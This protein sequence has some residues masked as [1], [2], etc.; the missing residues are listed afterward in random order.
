MDSGAARLKRRNLRDETTILQRGVGW[1]AQSPAHLNMAGH[2]PTWD[3]D[4][5]GKNMQRK[6][7]RLHVSPSRMFLGEIESLPCL[8]TRMLPV[9]I[10]HIFAQT[11][12]HK[13]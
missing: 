6:G 1:R 3:V 11:V 7:I 4:R 2:S 13:V 8:P 5:G 12:A 10:E 9:E